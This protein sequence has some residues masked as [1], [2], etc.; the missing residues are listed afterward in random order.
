MKELV[1]KVL[2]KALKKEK[3]ELK[4]EEIS[5]LLEMPPN[6][7]MGDYAFP[8]FFLADKLKQAPNQIALQIRSNIGNHPIMDFDDIQTSGAYINFFIKRKIWKN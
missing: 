5:N 8:C 3:I 1:I 6:Q 4:D 2:K 7:D